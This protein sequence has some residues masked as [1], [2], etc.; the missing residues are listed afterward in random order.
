MED[1][2]HDIQYSTACLHHYFFRA[3]SASCHTT[4]NF[5]LQSL[6]AAVI[7]TPQDRN[8]YTDGKS[9]V[10]SKNAK[11][12]DMKRMKLSFL[13]FMQSGTGNQLNILSII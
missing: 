1:F 3:N 2:L 12:K 6:I 4:I 9:K 10:K 11:A 7:K 13:T 8:I 5:L